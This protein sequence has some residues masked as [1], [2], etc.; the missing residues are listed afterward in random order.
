MLTFAPAIEIH[1]SHLKWGRRAIPWR[2]IRRV[3]QTK[4]AVP[5]ALK[6][7]LQDGRHLLLIYPGDPDSSDNLLRHI[8]RNA[9]L[10]LLD[11][12]PY[13]QFWGEPPALE[14]RVLAGPKYQ[15]LR[16]EDE[17]EIERMFRRLKSVGRLEPRGSDEE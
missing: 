2:D 13:R 15:L 9:R 16:P 3:D 12:V 6:L 10:A 1:E 5:L 17:A 11:G 8:R 4:W 14:P 7:A